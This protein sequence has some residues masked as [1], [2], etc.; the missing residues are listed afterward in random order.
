MSFHNRLGWI[1]RKV[2]MTNVLCG[3]KVCGVT[4]VQILKQNVISKKEEDDCVVL[5][6][7]VETTKLRAKPQLVEL[8]KLEKPLC[9]LIRE[10]RITAEEAALI[11]D[12]YGIDLLDSEKFL[13]VSANGIGKGFAGGMKRWNFQGAGASHGTSLTHRAI[14]STGTREKNWPNKKMP[15]RLGGKRITIQSLPVLEVDK[16]L[17]LVALHGSVPGKAGTMVVLR[18]ALKK[19]RSAV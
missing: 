4:L 15:G 10:F 2:G 19:Q 16:E 1:G 14:G 8:Q 6:V 11:S 9:R 18:K 5:R 3:K 13:D 7:G 12:D 17:G